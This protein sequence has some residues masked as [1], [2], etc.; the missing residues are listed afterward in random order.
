M[1]WDAIAA[2][3]ELLGAVGV[4][5]SLVYLAGQLRSAGGQARQ[6][7]IQS[8]VNQMNNVWTHLATERGNANLWARGSKGFSNLEDETEI[9]QFSALLLSIFRPYEEIFHYWKEGRVEDWTWESI[10]TQC[11]SLMGAPGFKQW[12]ERR[13]SWFSTAFRDHVA[14]TL[15]EIPEYQRFVDERP[16]GDA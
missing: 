9:L 2:V 7:A 6:A 8:V 11:Q 14:A 16:S 13:N 4:I 12:W 5:A 3:A 1:N 15:A 10:S